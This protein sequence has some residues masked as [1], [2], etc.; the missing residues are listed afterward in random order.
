MSGKAS[1]I[2]SSQPHHA[3][4]CEL[5]Y[6]TPL[7]S[8]LTGFYEKN[9]TMSTLRLTGPFS[10]VQK[11]KKTGQCFIPTYWPLQPVHP[12]FESASKASPTGL[13]HFIWHQPN[14]LSLTIKVWNPSKIW[15][16]LVIVPFSFCE[17]FLKWRYPTTMGFPTRNDHFGV[18]WGYHH[19]RKH[20]YIITGNFLRLKT[21]EASSFIQPLM[22][23][24][25]ALT[26]QFRRIFQRGP[27]VML[28]L[29]LLLG[30]LNC[31][32]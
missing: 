2:T 16:Y 10:I 24:L 8:C 7:N 25:L 11:K 4:R 19:L 20:L 14:P 3:L 32:A 1:K 5:I 6:V 29:F 23:L 21:I 15:P 18:F 12:T 22:L 13:R 28:C 30:S 26:L 27:E 31:C 17:G 9:L